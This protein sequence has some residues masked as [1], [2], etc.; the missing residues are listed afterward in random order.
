MEGAATRHFLRQDPEEEPSPACKP[1]AC[2]LEPRALSGGQEQGQGQ[3]EPGE[4]QTGRP[5]ALRPPPRPQAE[6]GLPAQ[7]PRAPVLPLLLGG[8]DLGQ[9]SLSRPR[10]TCWGVA[11]AQSAGTCSSSGPGVGR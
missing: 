8:W 4:T 5:A 9:L 11:Q 7:R 2:S 10:S 3:G 6:D 1:Q